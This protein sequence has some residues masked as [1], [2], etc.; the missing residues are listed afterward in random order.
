[1]LRL[2]IYNLYVIRSRFQALVRLKSVESFN[3]SMEISEH[4]RGKK[5]FR[6]GSALAQLAEKVFI[7]QM[8]IIRLKYPATLQR[9]RSEQSGISVIIP[10]I[11]FTNN[12]TQRITIN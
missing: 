12:I 3:E 6:E 10:R 2:M 1:M 9:M 5:P 7:S 11:N 8:E 4:A